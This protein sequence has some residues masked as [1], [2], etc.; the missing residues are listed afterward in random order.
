MDWQDLLRMAPC[1]PCRNQTR[2]ETF[3]T[4]I[5]ISN[6]GCSKRESPMTLKM[7]IAPLIFAGLA[8][9]LVYTQPDISCVVTILANIAA[10]IS[11]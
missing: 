6:C 4:F 7:M 11:V 8:L 1:R 5:R 9:L 3:L 2:S 10:N